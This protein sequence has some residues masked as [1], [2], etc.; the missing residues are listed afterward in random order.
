[1]LDI[2]IVYSYDITNIMI[3]LHTLAYD[4]TDTYAY[5]IIHEKQKPVTLTG[6]SKH[7]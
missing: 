5:D 4:N 7:K 2:V 6:K 1:M 3:F